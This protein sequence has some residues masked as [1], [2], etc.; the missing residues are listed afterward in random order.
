MIDIE[1][2]GGVRITRFTGELTAE[3]LRQHAE[4]MT[5]DPD[6]DPSLD[7]LADLTRLESL[8]FDSTDVGEVARAFRR[9]NQG[10]DRR[11]AI[12]AD[13][14]VAYGYARAYEAQHLAGDEIRIFRDPKEAR[15]WL[16]LAER[17]E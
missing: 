13:S 15:A 2:E 16:G 12:V 5:R 17:A 9:I 11:V 8:R 7:S 6:Y 3:D 4:L 10:H 1:V 14:P